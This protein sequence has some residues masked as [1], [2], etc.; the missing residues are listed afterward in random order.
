MPF[1]LIFVNQLYILLSYAGAGIMSYILKH[2]MYY[3]V[4]SPHFV[5]QYYVRE[6][7]K[8]VDGVDVLLFI[9]FQVAMLY[10]LLHCFFV[11]YL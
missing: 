7:L 9:L 6:E 5:F 10:R 3:E 2:W 11:C 1:H 8:L 4:T